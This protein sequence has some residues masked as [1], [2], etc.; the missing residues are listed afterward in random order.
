MNL[1][2]LCIIKIRMINRFRP[3]NGEIIDK[4]V[5]NPLLSPLF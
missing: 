2:T 1:Y 4:K 3:I 5:Y